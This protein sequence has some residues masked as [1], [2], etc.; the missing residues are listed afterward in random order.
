ML[1]VLRLEKD[2]CSLP[3]RVWKERKTERGSVSPSARQEVGSTAACELTVVRLVLVLLHSP[4]HGVV[5]DPPLRSHF[6]LHIRL[7]LVFACV[8]LSF[9]SLYL[10]QPRPSLSLS[11]SFYLSCVRTQALPICLT[12]ALLN[13]IIPK[14][15]GTNC[16]RR[17]RNRRKRGQPTTKAMIM[18]TQGERPPAVAWFMERGRRRRRPGVSLS[19]SLSLSLSGRTQ[20]RASAHPR[21]Q[22]KRTRENVLCCVVLWVCLSSSSSSSSSYH[23]GYH[24]QHAHKVPP[25]MRHFH[26]SSGKPPLASL[27][28]PP[29]LPSPAIF[30]PKH[31]Q[32]E[33]S[34]S[35]PQ[36][37]GQAGGRGRGESLQRERRGCSGGGRLWARQ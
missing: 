19:L 37:G 32:V 13:F 11:L 1:S 28:F 14:T 9:P 15:S 27:A 31:F 24:H 7:L 17:R 23:S 8:R 12:G 5:R 29:S 10:Q 3:F 25:E 36:G 21:R 34:R 33:I 35:G 30:F 6:Q 16:K 4:L 18:G 2:S 26:H 22:R 20:R